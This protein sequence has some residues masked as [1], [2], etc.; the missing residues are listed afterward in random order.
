MA[1]IKEVGDM[2]ARACDEVLTSLDS[3]IGVG[4]TNEDG[5]FELVVNDGGMVKHYQ[6]VVVRL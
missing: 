4:S 2:V 6:I 1:G 5:D 3:V